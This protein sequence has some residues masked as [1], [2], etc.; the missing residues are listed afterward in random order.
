MAAGERGRGSAAHLT[1]KNRL[2]AWSLGAQLNTAECARQPTVS[3][4]ARRTKK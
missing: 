4:A 2:K 1:V 3:G